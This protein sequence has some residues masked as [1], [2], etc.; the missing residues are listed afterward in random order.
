VFG[1]GLCQF[2]VA[3]AA[4]GVEGGFRCLG[5]IGAGGAVAIAAAAETGL[6]YEVVMAGDAGDGRVLFVGEV[7]GE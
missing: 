6:V 2:G 4:E 3:V 1:G 5:Q 7:E